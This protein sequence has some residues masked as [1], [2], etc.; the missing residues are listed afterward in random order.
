VARRIGVAAVRPCGATI[1]LSA[2]GPKLSSGL[3]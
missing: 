2:A 3:G 1:L